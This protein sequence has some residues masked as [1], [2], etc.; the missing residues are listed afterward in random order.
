VC[1][2]HFQT[3]LFLTRVSARTPSNRPNKKREKTAATNPGEIHFTRF[4]ATL[5]SLS[6]IRASST[7]KLCSQTRCSS[8]NEE[9]FV[10]RRGTQP[11]A[12][13]TLANWDCPHFCILY[14]WI[15][16]VYG[17]DVPSNCRQSR[18]LCKNFIKNILLYF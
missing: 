17:L 16:A 3:K 12:L 8:A 11:P 14:C 15:H 4:H 13:L 9:H 2:F 5:C 7:G 18:I 1:H 6:A 10:G